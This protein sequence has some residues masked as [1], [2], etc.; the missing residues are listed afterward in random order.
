MTEAQVLAKLAAG[1]I[2]A[3]QAQKE[4]ELAREKPLTL[5]IGE[6]GGVCVY[7]LQRFPV[8]LYPRQWTRLLTNPAIVAQILALSAELQAKVDAEAAK[9]AEDAAEAA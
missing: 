7:G 4:L 8:T 5:K 2:N 9:P 3:A 1:E 6:K